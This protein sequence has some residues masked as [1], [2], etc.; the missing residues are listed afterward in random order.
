[1]VVKNCVLKAVIAMITEICCHFLFEKG[2]VEQTVLEPYL[3]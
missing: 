2:R 1:M 3:P